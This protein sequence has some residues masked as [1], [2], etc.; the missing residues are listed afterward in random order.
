MQQSTSGVN[1]LA[2]ELDQLGGGSS[3][4]SLRHKVVVLVKKT[5]TSSTAVRH[6]EGNLRIRDPKAPVHEP[7]AERCFKVPSVIFA[8]SDAHGTKLN[9]E[10]CKVRTTGAM[11][12]SPLA[13]VWI[14]RRIRVG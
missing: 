11:A 9:E 3:V 8:D 6:T 14:T 13:N 2:A 12:C 7:S 4:Q 10:T 5:G 1:K